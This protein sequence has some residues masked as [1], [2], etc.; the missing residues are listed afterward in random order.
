[1]RLDED[2]WPGGRMT[3]FILWVG[4]CIAALRREQPEA[5]AG[6]A[7]FNHKAKIRLMRE[8]GREFLPQEVNFKNQT[9]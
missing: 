4:Q 1:M 5:V 9:P 6:C 8:R 7:V 2:A 3:G